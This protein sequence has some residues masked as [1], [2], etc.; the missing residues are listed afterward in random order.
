MASTS[1]SFDIDFY[2]KYLRSSC[3]FA[4]IQEDKYCNVLNCLKA[5]IE[6]VSAGSSIVS[7][8]DKDFRAG[9]VLEGG[10]E[11]YIFDENGNHAAIRHLTS[12]DVF[13]AELA[14]GSSLASQFYLDASSDSSLLILDFENLLSETTLTC[15]NRMQV[16]ASLLQE[17]ANQ[18]TFF[19]MKVR[20]LSQKK[21][22]DKI[23]VYL[24]TLEI[25][26]K[27]IIQL[28]MSRNKLAEF[29]YVDR[30]ALSREF[31]R[32][33]DDGILTFSGSKIQMIDKDFLSA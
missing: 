5:R 27:G 28:P 13:G 33:R 22:R 8:G 9:M 31:C 6:N 11:E 4:G 15:T 30:S 32:M 14:C 25:S 29:L 10:L 2:N 3:L 7:A 18:I 16:T 12:G 23:K 17:L 24:Q 26:D 20:I 19:N 1:E 21:L